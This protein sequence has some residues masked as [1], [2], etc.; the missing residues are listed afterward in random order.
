MKFRTN[1]KRFRSRL[2]HHLYI[3]TAGLAA[4]G[5][6]YAVLLY[7]YA[8]TQ[9]LA[10][11]LSM[12]TAYVAAL[13]L[14]IT[15]TLGAWN[16][17]RGRVNPV[18]SDWRRDVG[19]WCGAFTLAHVLFGLNVHL[20]HWTQY[21]FGNDGRLLTDAFGF[22][23]YLGVLATLI[24]VVLLATSNDVALRRFGRGRWKAIQRW[25]YVFALVTGLHAVVYQFVEKRLMPFGAIL[26]VIVLWTAA[27]QFAGWR[28]K[29]REIKVAR[30]N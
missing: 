15:L 29:R 25:N 13:L 23:N 19:I 4:T 26:G 24:V 16:V 1:T 8:D 12:T 5:V 14:A 3:S 7:F 11:R 10:F 6:I 18:S 27:I 30:E 2:R 17:F 22:A 21:F 20:Q 9:Q 28:A